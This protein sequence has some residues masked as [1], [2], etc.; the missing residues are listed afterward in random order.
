MRQTLGIV[1]VEGLVFTIAC[2]DA[3]LK[4][5]NIELLGYESSKG[6][7]RFV[8]KFTGNV[9]AVNAAIDSAI[10]LAKKNGKV[11]VGYAIPRPAEECWKMIEQEGAGT[12]PESGEEAALTEEEKPVEEVEPAEEVEVKEAETEEDSEA[13]T[14]NI[15]GD[16][17]CHRHKG[18]PHSMC[19][20]YND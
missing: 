5:A 20:H 12:E 17:A 8:L 6:G 16:P 4:S 19:I 10:A 1:E 3:A 13:V 14:C 9:G 15:C 7:G 18:D 2:A 11:V